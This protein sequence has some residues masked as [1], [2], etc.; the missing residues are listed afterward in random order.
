MRTSPQSGLSRADSAAFPASGWQGASYGGSPMSARPFGQGSAQAQSAGSQA[1]QDQWRYVRGRAQ[2]TPLADEFGKAVQQPQQQQG[3]AQQQQQ[4]PPPP[5]PGPQTSPAQQQQMDYSSYSMPAPHQPSSG[6]AN[7]QPHLFN[8]EEQHDQHMRHLSEQFGL[9]QVDYGGGGGRQQQS[10]MQHPPSRQSL[11]G[12]P[13]QSPTAYQ[14]H[15]A[16]SAKHDA[17]TP[18]QQQPMYYGPY[19]R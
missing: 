19:S 15:S 2:T 7:S 16:G 18:Q 9:G 1:A 8:P 13:V 14:P 12:M 6:R 10:M 11:P 3:P 5:Q 4:P 17:T